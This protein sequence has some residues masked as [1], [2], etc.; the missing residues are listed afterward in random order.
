[1][2]FSNRVYDILKWTAQ[3][4]LP[5]FGAAYYSLAEIWHL[6][7][8]TEVV[9]TIVVVDTFLGALLGIS[10]VAYNKSDAPYDGVIHVG[11][12]GEDRDVYSLVMNDYPN[13]LPKRSSVT[14]KVVPGLE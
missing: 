14:F 12:E 9:G 3:V 2:Y 8:A 11:S 4:F 6:P 1:M 10:T 7:N 5:A 13:E